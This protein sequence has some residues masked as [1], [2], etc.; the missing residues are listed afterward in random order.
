M[1]GVITVSFIKTEQDV[2]MPMISCLCCN[3]RLTELNYLDQ[4]LQKQLLH[5]SK[6]GHVQVA[7]IPDKKKLY[8]Y[9]QNAYSADRKH[10]FSSRYINIMKKRALSQA[11]YIGNYIRIGDWK[12]VDYG[13]GFGQTLEVFRKNGCQVSGYDYDEVAVNYCKENNIN[14]NLMP[15]DG[16]INLEDTDIVI[17][18]HILEHLDT[19]D[20]TMAYI[21]KHANYIFIEVPAYDYRINEQFDNQEGHLNFF[22]YTSLHKYLEKLSFEIVDIASYGPSMNL[23]WKSN[24]RILRYIYRSFTRDYFYNRYNNRCDSGIWIRALVKC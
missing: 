13:C 15:A 7:V 21:K 17:M 23:F 4:F 2:N 16:I 6:C 9:Y 10:M 22:T 3:S 18:S 8:E 11:D 12:V 20:V 14:A 1:P 19:P 24:F 5:C